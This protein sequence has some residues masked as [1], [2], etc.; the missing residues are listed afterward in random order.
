M[1]GQVIILERPELVHTSTHLAHLDKEEQVALLYEEYEPIVRDFSHAMH[2]L[3][4]RYVGISAPVV[5]A[6][7]H[8]MANGGCEVL[9]DL[10]GCL[11]MRSQTLS[12]QAKQLEEEF[13]RQRRTA[14][15]LARLAR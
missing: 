6:I 14:C 15:A 1:S 2:D 4:G 3:H 11:Q 7:A 13:Q 9:E 12:K 5:N 8:R 10:V